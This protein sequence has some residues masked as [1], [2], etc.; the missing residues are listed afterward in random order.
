MKTETLNPKFK[1]RGRA[2]IDF[3]ISMYKGS[4]SVRQKADVDLA[5]AAGDVDALPDDM[6]ARTDVIMRGLSQSRAQRVRSLVG[7][8]HSRNH[9]NICGRAF[10]E[11]FPELEADLTALHNGP[12]ELYLDPDLKAPAYW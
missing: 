12:A 7:E 3:L 8:W 5:A 2:E 1:Q 6:D 11:T 10:E 9:A 4:V